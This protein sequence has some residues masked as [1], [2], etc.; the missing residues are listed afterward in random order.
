MR[1]TLS[2]RSLVPL[3]VVPMIAC[4]CGTTFAQD[5]VTVPDGPAGYVRMPAAPLD[6]SAQTVSDA[7]LLVF[8]S[9]ADTS[10]ASWSADVNGASNSA[11][12]ENAARRDSA[13][14]GLA[15]AA[16]P[17]SPGHAATTPAGY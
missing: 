12:T 16:R 7:P 1:H 11:G 14:A 10:K 17:A 2:V 15:A 4:L 5:D 13:E 9:N 6:S 3:L 8:P